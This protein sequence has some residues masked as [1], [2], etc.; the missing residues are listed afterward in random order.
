MV[1]ARQRNALE[2]HL[3]LHVEQPG[4]THQLGRP[5]PRHG[6]AGRGGSSISAGA[7]YQ[8]PQRN[9]LFSLGGVYLR[10]G[11]LDQAE[12]LYQKALAVDP[13]DPAGRNN[14]GLVLVKQGRYDEALKLYRADPG[15]QPQ[16]CRGPLQSGARTY[17]L[18]QLD[19]AI[20]QYRYAF[21]TRAR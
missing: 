7:G 1:L 13:S 17:N 6:A 20:E 21:E 12:E 14:L 2:P 5:F 9:A 16:L 4:R 15:G 8:P 19:G 11:Q 10:L 18:G 3:G